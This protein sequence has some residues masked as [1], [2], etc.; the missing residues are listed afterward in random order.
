MAVNSPVMTIMMRAA[1]KAGRSLIR[2]F[3]EV[4]NLQISRK[5]PGDFV[6]A[7]D[8]R[9]EE[10]IYNELSKAR[11]D[12]A[13]LM[14][15]SGAKGNQNSEYRWIIDPLDGTSNFLHGLPHWC[16]SIALE[17]K[18]EIVAGLIADPIKDDI[19][20]A[21]K[22]KGAFMKRRRLRVSGRDSAEPS[23]IAIGQPG[24]AQGKRDRF[25]AEYKAMQA[26]GFGLRRFG[27]AALDLA[28]VAAGRYEGFWERDLKAWDVAAGYL[29]VKEAG[30][31]V[32][33]I[34][35]KKANPVDTG[36]ILAAN[37]QLFEPIRKIL[38]KSGT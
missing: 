13:F 8:R 36:S 19:F 37:E 22:G 1:E 27:A 3:N 15:E 5:G 30:G 28:Y 9:S 35:D 11:P 32:A 20:S 38:A 21:E 23:M 31:F 26:A 6:S 12:Y 4:E 34:D 7:A 17:H 16:I 24:R 33:D 2:D 14:E 18:G 29:I 10:I 25:N